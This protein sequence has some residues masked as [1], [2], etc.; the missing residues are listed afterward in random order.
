MPFYSLIRYMG[1][2]FVIALG[3][4]KIAS[5]L[6]ILRE[7]IGILI[8]IAISPLLFKIY[9]LKWK[10]YTKEIAVIIL[11]GLFFLIRA[12]SLKYFLIF[13]PIII[14]MLGSVLNK[15]EIKWHCI[16]SIPLIIGLILAYGFFSAN[17]TM[18]QKDLSNIVSDY[19]VNYIIA[20]PYQAPFIA[21]FLW[22][23]KPY[24]AWFEDYNASMNNK[25]RIRGYDFNFNSNIP[26]K[27]KLEISASF[28]RFDDNKAYDNY[29]IVSREKEMD[30]FK[31]D[32]CYELLC[33]FK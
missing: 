10:E 20:E 7:P 28:V 14:I 23:N 5:N 19:N 24:V 13:S 9:K 12:A 3:L 32:K 2:N 29:I 1:T 18:I 6:Q 27:D 30:G 11:A 16:L 33:V 8:V 31:L 15:K 25:T 17:E 22:Q 26:L 21:G 4:N